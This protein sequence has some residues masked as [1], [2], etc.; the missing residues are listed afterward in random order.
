MTYVIC[1]PCVDVKDTACVD[2]CPVDCIHT[3]EGENQLYINPAECI[4]CAACE[5][6][7]PVT[8]IF[9][10][11]A[12][13]AEWES[14]KELN[15]KF[16]ETFVK[17][18]SSDEA[19]TG[20]D[21]KGFGKFREADVEE[22]AQ[23]PEGEASSLRAPFRPL[24]M[25]A[26]P[27][28]GAFSARFKNELEEMAGNATIFSAAISTG[29]NSFINLILYPTLLFL[30][31]V[32]GDFFAS[33]GNGFILLGIV[34]AIAEGIVRFRDVLVAT[35]N[36]EK[37][38]YG[39][40]LYGWIPSLVTYPLLSAL[41]KGIAVEQTAPRTTVPGAVLTDGPI[42]TDDVRERY[43]RYGMINQVKEMPDYYTIGI[44]M[45][46][47][48][49]DSEYKK[50]YDLPDRMPDYAYQITLED[51]TVIIETKLEDPRFAQVLGR[52]SSF[53]NGFQNIFH[54]EGQPENYK[55]AY[56]DNLLEVIIPKAGKV[57]D[58][59]IEQKVHYAK[60]KG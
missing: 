17:P 37:P 49:P 5:P 4:D 8:A 31:A 33:K 7:C 52:S 1:E 6:E 57:E 15:N 22:F 39:A 51:N 40:A 18:E 42:Y 23:L 41:R 29:I 19:G 59:S 10:A 48:V 34:I 60:L 58:I 25:V 56:R 35:E 54:I 12:V 16:F 55:V 30:L 21:G 45:P 53:P 43:R 20:A 9:I 3:V 36:D 50:L 28:L 2:V 13:P 47:W 26:Q 46:H 11:D 38:R 24:V 44:E 27:I 32:R 14:Y